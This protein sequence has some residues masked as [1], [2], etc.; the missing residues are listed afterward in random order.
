FSD[1]TEDA[2]KEGRKKHQG[3]ESKII[4]YRTLA[5]AV[6]VKDTVP[7]EMV[8]GYETDKTRYVKSLQQQFA[9]LKKQYSVHVKGL[10]QTGGGLK[11]QD[12]QDNLIEKI[13]DS[14]PYWDELDGFW[15]ELPNYNPIGVSNSTGGVDHGVRA[16]SL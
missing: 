8:Q 4:M 11:A 16:E 10:Y 5:D 7:E 14:F 2:T 13:K 15:R 6:F 1:S 9:R 3:K 12:Q